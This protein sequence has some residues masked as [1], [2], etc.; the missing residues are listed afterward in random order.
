MAVHAQVQTQGQSESDLNKL[1]RLQ[2]QMDQLQQQMQSLK[3]DI[4]QA[5]KKSLDHDSLQ[6]AYG[7]DA[8]APRSKGPL[9]KAM[10]AMERIHVTVGGFFAAESVWRQHNETSE[11][12]SSFTGEPF[13]FAP[14]F[15]E[16]EY[17]ASARQSRLSLLV[18]GNIDPKQK[19]TGYFETDFLGVGVTSNYNQSNSWAPRMR[20]FFVDYDNAYSGFHLLAGQAWSLITQNTSGIVARKE[21]IPLTIDPNYVVGFEFTRNYQV[22]M[23]QEFGPMFTAAVSVEAPAEQVFAGGVANGGIVNGVVANWTNP[24]GSFLATGTDPTTFTADKIPDIIEKVAFDPGWAHF[25]L[26]GVERFFSDNIF[27]CSL[28]TAAGVCNGLV[29]ANTGTTNN[30]VTSGAGIGGS[31]LW[32]VLP[33][34]LDLDGMVIAGKG[35]GRYSAAQLPDV[36][37]AGDGTLRPVKEIAG[38]AGAVLHPWVGTDIYAYAGIEKEDA[39]WYSGFTPGAANLGLGNPNLLNFGCGIVTAA[40]FSGGANNCAGTNHWVTDITV[41]LWQNLYN[42]DIGRFAWGVQYEYLNRKLFP[43]LSAPP[44]GSPL[45]AP[46]TNDNIVFTSLRWYPKYPTY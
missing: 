17:R 11:L 16:N 26:F 21:N 20:Q 15:G 44:L 37:V 31:F 29:A 40:S 1:D 6:N 30:H 7:A 23:V 36:I 5:K 27:S 3:G 34:F 25:E 42:G 18:E 22:R 41:G 46:S 19:L 43:G 28:L 9:V 4:A 24:G 32:P 13:P 39:N 14:T 10:P 2:R 33:S 8:G 12:G 45:V 38:M 35:I